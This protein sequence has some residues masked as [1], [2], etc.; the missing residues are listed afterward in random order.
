MEQARA[1]HQVALQVATDAVKQGEAANRLL[2]ATNTTLSKELD[3]TKDVLAQLQSA[4]HTQTVA[5]AALQAENAGLQQ[6]MTDRQREIDGLHRQLDQARI[7]FEHYQEATAV[8]RAE[9][10]QQAEQNRLRVENELTQARQNA[11]VQKAALA[12]RELDLTH[13][14][15][16][17]DHAATALSSLQA[18]YTTLQAQH[19]HQA[20]QIQTSEA[21]LI[22]LRT[23]VEATSVALAQ[24]RSELAVLSAEKPQLQSRIAALET[25]VQS[26]LDENKGLT[27]DKARL[28]GMHS[29]PAAQPS[30][31]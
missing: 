17:K 24:A 23:Q 30:S 8:Q 4:H 9:E 1:E 13:L 21:V 19:R 28:E 29:R 2:T 12:Q 16:D 10:R 22:E 6:R 20:Q 26:L 11:A 31:A 18:A 3:E 7:Q 15:Q 25:K 14:Q 27:I 5:M